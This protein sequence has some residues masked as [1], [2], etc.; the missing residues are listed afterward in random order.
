MENI[1]VDVYFN[2]TRKVFSIRQDGIVIAHRSNLFLTHSKFIVR[3]SGQK[4][5]RE[6]GHKNVHA[7]VRGMW[8]QKDY[9]TFKDLLLWR[10]V[11]YNP[12]RDNFFM[13]QNKFDPSKYEEVKRDFTY[14]VALETENGKPIT[15][16]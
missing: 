14:A 11:S 15:R 3:E 12:K 1:E 13:V 2:V 4:R 5:V 16:I 10:R 7:F 6:T 8:N 9:H